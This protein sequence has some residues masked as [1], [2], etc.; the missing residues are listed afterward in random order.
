[1][2]EAST[3]LGSQKGDSRGTNITVGKKKNT[4]VNVKYAIEKRLMINPHLP[5]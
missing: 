5:R 4:I 1:M 3:G 2:L